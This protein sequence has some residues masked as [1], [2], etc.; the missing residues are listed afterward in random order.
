[1]T[2][3]I[4]VISDTHGRLRAEVR[5]RLEGCDYI[6]HAGDFDRREILEELEEIAPVCAVRGNNDWGGWAGKLPRTRTVELGGV[7]FFLVHNRQHTP[8]VLGDVQVVAVAEPGQL[9][10]AEIWRGHIH[11]GYDGGGR[12]G[13][14]RAD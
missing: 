11:G 12:R 5:R 4:G 6:F 8:Q 1:M 3:K 13:P 9:C 7:N 14:G 2:V 10:V